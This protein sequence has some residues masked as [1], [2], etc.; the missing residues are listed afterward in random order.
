M[1]KTDQDN[2]GTGTAKAVARFM[3]FAQITCSPGHA[4]DLA[5]IERFRSSAL[6]CPGSVD[7]VCAA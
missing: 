5:I 7:L 3:S 1:A 4:S 6:C 2:L